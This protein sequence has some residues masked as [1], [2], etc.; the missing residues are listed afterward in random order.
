MLHT[1][2]Q[3]SRPFCFRQEDFSM[4]SLYNPVAN[5]RPRAKPFL[6][7]GAKFEQTW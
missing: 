7:P 1:K 6:V 5:M 3:G 4:F 2:Y